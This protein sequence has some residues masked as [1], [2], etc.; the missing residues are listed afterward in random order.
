MAFNTK[1]LTDFKSK[2][3]G[4]GARPN[5]FEVQL[6]AFPDAIKEAWKSSDSGEAGIMQF[7]CKA[8]NLPAST[9]N[10]VNVPFRGRQLKVAGERTID[11]W[12]VTIIND[13]DFKLRTAFERW[14]NVMSK[15]DD[16]TGVT[17]PTSYMTDAYVYQLGRGKEKFADKNKGGSSAVLRSYR[18]YDIWP[19]AVQAIDLSYD[20]ENTLEEF[21][22]E[23][24]VQWF[25][26]G[27]KDDGP[28]VR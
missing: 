17:N 27:E 16:A 8:T 15:L 9:V 21:T 6:P 4:G 18:F 2:L 1:S 24:Q 25:T 20:T 10:P 26:V 7:M 22:V 11:P 23:F 14:A 5:L 3:A 13:E 12:T 19:S 28:E